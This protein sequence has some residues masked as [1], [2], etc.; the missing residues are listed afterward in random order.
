M[1]LTALGITA[2]YNGSP[3]LH[4]VDV[5]VANGEWVA[6]IGPNGAGKTT[7]LRA[8]AGSI[9]SGGRLEVGHRDVV[10][11]SARHLAQ[12]VA[13]VP[14]QPTMPAG[15]T[16]LD[17]ALLGRT[18]YIPWWGV[19]SGSDV[20]RVLEVLDRLDLGGLEGRPLD[21]LSGGEAQRAVLAR[22]LAQDAE[23]LL[24]DEP[25]AS[26]DIGHQQQVLGL[27][28][29]LRHERGLAVLSALHDLTLAGQYADRLILLHH[30]RCVV[31]G[32]PDVVLDPDT[33][34]ARYG[35]DVAV[36]RDPEGGLVVAPRRQIR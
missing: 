12:R 35:A 20:Q 22:A 16:V 14:Q 30:G 32:T 29:E 1:S 18:P 2:A 11:L 6:L 13:V 33:L 27:V 34:R 23:L 7:L 25:T 4:G 28:D 24:L 19:E 8:V 31:Q 36:L 10:G 21:R 26:L 17:Y 5:E 9:A 3:V 15:M